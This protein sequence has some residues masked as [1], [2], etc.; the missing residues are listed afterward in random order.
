MNMLDKFL[1]KAFAFP[2]LVIGILASVGLFVFLGSF[3][4]GQANE[5]FD[6]AAFAFGLL[7]ISL[8]AVPIG[9][10]VRVPKWLVSPETSPL[11]WR[12]LM[13]V[14]FF[15][16]FGGTMWPMATTVG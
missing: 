11:F 13:L 8:S 4:G 12:L 1:L 2:F 3:P 9:L 15:L 14:P 7:G 16:G 6:I 5:G 10:S